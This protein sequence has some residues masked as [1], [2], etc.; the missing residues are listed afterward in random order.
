MKSSH[1][2]K[3]SRSDSLDLS[4]H[5][6]NQTFVPFTSTS[7][8][9]LLDRE[10][11]R[12]VLEIKRAKYANIAHIVDGELRFGAK[13]DDLLLP[14][15]NPDLREGSMF[16]KSYG[17]FP[18][19]LL[20]VP[21]EEIDPGIREKTFVVISSR[22]KK[23]YINRF[24]ATKSLFVFTPWNP[25][26]KFTV[27]ISTHQLFDVFIFLTII[28]NCIFLAMTHDQT[29]EV[30]EYV[31]L[32]I[33]TLECIIKIVGRG[34]IIGSYTYMHDP[35]NWLDIFV[36]FIAF[37]TILVQA[38]FPSMPVKDTKGLR[39]FR[40]LRA[41]RTV[42]I[43]PGLKTIVSALVQAF[44]MLI[45]VMLLTMFCLMIFAI[46]AVKAFAG[47]LRQKC[48]LNVTGY[49]DSLSQ[50]YDDY[51]VQWIRNSSN[52]YKDS[53]NQHAVCGNNTGAGL[54]PQGYICIPNVGDN[55]RNGFLNFDHFGWAALASFQLIALD[56]WEDIYNKVV[57]AKGPWSII[58]FIIVV[59]FGSFFLMNLMLAVVSISYEE[60]A[61][62][63]GKEREREK[64]ENA[65]KK[66]CS[67]PYFR[68]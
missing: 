18:P 52:W 11:V 44:K 32:G 42:S 20:G 15:E 13:E 40:V 58:F 19:H 12:K 45:E 25:V 9:R 61:L 34:F 54:C 64:K 50:T 55:P 4:S 22:Y 8:Q 28:V 27:A 1:S 16:T 59:Y 6:D 24:S 26:R 7:Y 62:K 43:V 38:I 3:S 2:G 35:W 67:I 33:Y 23:K 57:R 21:I 49:E 14:E 5:G 56:F 47:A 66:T 68:V 10:R 46:F 60:E 48:V 36:I 17:T 63:A 39:T 51:Y 29:V 53:E 37:L 65:R 30:M 41:L 31:F